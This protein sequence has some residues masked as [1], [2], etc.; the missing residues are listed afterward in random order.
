MAKRNFDKLFF[1][2]PE[3]AAQWGVGPDKIIDLIHKGEL[4]AVN[5]SLHKL[6]RPRWRISQ[7][8]AERFLRSRES[9]P[10]TP[11]TAPRRRKLELAERYY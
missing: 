2:P 1:S 3:L 7:A 9:Q 11:A 5:L 8:E 10:A 4:V 6:A